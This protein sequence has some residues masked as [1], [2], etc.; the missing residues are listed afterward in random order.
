MK[1]SVKQE[2]LHYSFDC[3]LPAHF[4]NLCTGFDCVAEIRRKSYLKSK[5]ISMEGR[6]AP[7]SLS[8]KGNEKQQGVSQ[9]SAKDLMREILY[10]L[11]PRTFQGFQ[12]R[13]MSK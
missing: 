12:A 6:C 1:F 10:I 2:V 9:L 5:Q 3:R 13:R 4:D 7:K 11:R 8:R